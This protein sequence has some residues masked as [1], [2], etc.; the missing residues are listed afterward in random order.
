MKA[1][2]SHCPLL[3]SSASW[4]PLMSS[5][6]NTAWHAVPPLSRTREFNTLFFWAAPLFPVVDWSSHKRIQIRIDITHIYYPTQIPAIYQFQLDVILF[7][8]PCSYMADPSFHKTE[9]IKQ[10][11]Q[12]RRILPNNLVINVNRIYKLLVLV[13]FW[14]KIRYYITPCPKISL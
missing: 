8:W 4:P 10:N 5:A 3:P 1:V 11:Y 9:H 12:K 7:A 6:C 13:L 2:A 14:K